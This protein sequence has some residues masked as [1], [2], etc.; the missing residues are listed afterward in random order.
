MLGSQEL[1]SRGLS[2]DNLRSPGSVVADREAVRLSVIIDD[3]DYDHVTA[4]HT[5]HR[6]RRRLVSAIIVAILGADKC[7]ITSRPNNPGAG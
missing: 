3:L 4:V 6:P 2:P 7:K 5:H 1:D